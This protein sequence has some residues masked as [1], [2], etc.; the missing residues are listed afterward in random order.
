M[1]SRTQEMNNDGDAKPN[2]EHNRISREK[3]A[4]RRQPTMP[5]GR[6][7]IN[8]GRQPVEIFRTTLAASDNRMSPLIPRM[9]ALQAVRRLALSRNFGRNV[10]AARAV[11]S[12]G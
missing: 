8:H 12:F 3:P 6:M 7:S 11:I 1:S 10:W 5:A 9:L 2:A 4:H